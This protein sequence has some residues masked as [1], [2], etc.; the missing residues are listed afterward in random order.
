[1]TGDLFDAAARARRGRKSGIPLA[2]RMRPR[3]FDDLVGQKAVAP[4]SLLR[5]ALQR[6]HLPSLLLFGPPGARHTFSTLATAAVL[7]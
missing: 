4:G 1:M 5:S 3:A 6:E 7:T 2:E